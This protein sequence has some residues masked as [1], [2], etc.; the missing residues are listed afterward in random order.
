MKTSFADLCAS[1]DWLLADGATGTN[2]FRAGL[3][4][5][6]PPELW[7][8]E[9]PDRVTG[10]H[11]AFI[12]AG[13][14]ILLTN[15]FGGTAHR[16]KLHQAETRVAELNEA[17]ARL[18][19][20]VADAADKPVLVAGSMGPTG[21]L[22]EPLGALTPDEAEQA[23]AEQAIALA[24]GGADLLWIETMSSLEEIEAAVKGARHA[25]LPVAATMTFDTAG[26]TM[27]GITPA[28]YADVAANLG[29]DAFG[30][31]CG[32]GPAE[33]LDSI[34]GFVE[35]KAE[36][37]M[38]AKGNCGIPAYVDG[39][40][41]YHGTPELMADYA[42]LARDSGVKI[43]GGCCGTSPEH[44]KAMAHALRTTPPAG[45]ATRQ[46]VAAKLGEAWSNVP[47]KPTSEQAERRRRRRRG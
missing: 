28:A 21:E 1:R 43:I 23:F 30:A 41:H 44:V 11:S 2:L 36:L 13:A 26:R 8:V 39:E 22:F 14:D 3:E 17:A 27:M 42:V 4:T 24:A 16:L 25:D 19:R 10:L 31:N 46:D 18:A 35:H 33:L 32:I 9:H 15:S 47:E 34:H 37:L 12:D 5:G 40:I 45:S 38:V 20:A 6:Y 29:L 7:N